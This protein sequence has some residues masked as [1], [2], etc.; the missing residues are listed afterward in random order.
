MLSLDT[1]FVVALDLARRQQHVLGRHC[2]DFNIPDNSN[3]HYR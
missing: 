2:R 1:R 3:K